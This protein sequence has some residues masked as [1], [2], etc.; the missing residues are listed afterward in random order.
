MIKHP[1]LI[2][3]LFLSFGN[4][5]KAQIP[6]YFEFRPICGYD[7]WQDT[8]FRA[9]TSSQALADA[10]LA[11]LEK[12]YE[13]RKFILGAIDHGHGGH[14]RN[15]PHWF[16]WHFIPDQWEL[17]EQ[18]IEL[19]DGCPYSDIDQDTAYWIGVLGQFC[20]WSGKPVREVTNTVSNDDPTLEE[21]IELYPN[22]AENMFFLRSDGV[23]AW[24]IVIANA[25][26]QIVSV[27]SG[28][29]HD[30]GLDISHLPA[31]I[32]YVRLSAGRTS[33]VKKMVV[34]GR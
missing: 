20:P 2:L 6:R 9:V 32:Y 14:N 8:T 18:A 26:G 3:T 15:G 12:P 19:C 5:S 4:I 34:T 27:A 31:G 13:Q 1:L 16:L 29:N 7:A 25:V 10:V 11:E 22:P 28:G 33:V 21:S 24:D 30:E 17:A 23:K